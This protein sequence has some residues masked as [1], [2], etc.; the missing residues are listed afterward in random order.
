NLTSEKILL[1]DLEINKQILIQAQTQADMLIAK[2]V[3]YQPTTSI[4]SSIQAT[5]GNIMGTTIQLLNGKTRLDLSKTDLRPRFGCQS[6]S[7][8]DIT[9]GT[10]FSALINN[11]ATDSDAPLSISSAK[12]TTPIEATFFAMIKNIN[13]TDRSL[14]LLN[15]KV[16]TND[17]TIISKILNELPIRTKPAKF[18]S[19]KVGKFIIANVYLEGNDIVAV[20]ITRQAKMVKDFRGDPP[21]N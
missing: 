17:T 6:L 2:S 5:V 14:R 12:I 1:K 19:L 21:C 4:F 18:R 7:I 13:Y 3:F 8:S 15:Q 16:L 10:Q 20:A 9:I 11:I